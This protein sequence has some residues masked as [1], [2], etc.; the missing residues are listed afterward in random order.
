MNNCDEIL[1]RNTTGSLTA[2]TGETILESMK[3]LAV[4]ENPMVARAELHTMIQGHDEPVQAF[5]ARVRGQAAVPMDCPDCS[6]AVDY[7]EHVITDVVSHGLVDKDIQLDLL[8]NS[9]QAPSLEET[10]QFIEKKE[11]GK[12]SATHFSQTAL[13]QTV[14]TTSSSY[15]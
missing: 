6:N 15:R 8:G 3:K 1:T 12:R 2:K 5:C 4:R 11:S 9:N 13:G 14:A 7:T 10:L